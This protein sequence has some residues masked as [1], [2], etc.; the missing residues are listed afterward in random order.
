MSRW[1]SLFG[2]S[3]PREPLDD[4]P[5]VD[6]ASKA[7]LVKMNPLGLQRLRVLDCIGGNDRLG[8]GRFDPDSAG[9]VLDSFRA[10][11]LE[12]AAKWS[13]ETHPVHLSNI[14]AARMLIGDLSAADVIVELLPDK[15]RKLDHGA[16]RC[17]VAA[18]YALRAVLPLPP[19]L[20]D[21]ER[22]TAGSSEQ[23]ALRE[24][25]ARHRDELRWLEMEGEYRLSDGIDKQRASS[26]S[27]RA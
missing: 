4:R 6:A 9:S 20:T 8:G 3:R 22:W 12:A 25:L 23:A 16:G 5:D 26:V 13:E 7:R 10:Y 1:R 21:I 24:W 15:P 19:E 2:P 17:L 27:V 11:V 18:V 14:A